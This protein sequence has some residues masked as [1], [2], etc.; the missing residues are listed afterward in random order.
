[1]MQ[2]KDIV[3]EEF[4]S[5]KDL[6]AAGAGFDDV[7]YYFRV[8]SLVDST[9]IKSLKSHVWPS[10]TRALTRLAAYT[11]TTVLVEHPTLDLVQN[12]AALTS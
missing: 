4:S 8:P 10:L 7:I 1:M 5:T 6:R 9:P 12:C 11:R 3:E 2:T